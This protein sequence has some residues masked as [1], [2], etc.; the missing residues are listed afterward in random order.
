MRGQY[1]DLSE[2]ELYS[3]ADEYISDLE[4]YRN[5]NEMSNAELIKLARQNPGLI[6]TLQMMK[7]GASWEEAVARNVDLSAIPIEGDPDYEKWAANAKARDEEYGK[8]QEWEQ[9][10][11]ANKEV[12]QQNRKDFAEENVMSMEQAMEFVEK[13]LSP[14]LD[15]LS[16]L[17]FSKNFLKM[18]H[19]AVTK[20]ADVAAAKEEGMLEGKNAKIEET[21]MTPPPAGDGLPKGASAGAVPEMPKA[22]PSYIDSLKRK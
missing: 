22:K 13:H 12:S 6:R 14:I 8:A 10:L 17:N 21:I 1:P 18:I 20:E 16:N 5:R 3:K 4:D 2:D 9:T 11:A 7:E 15:E 19:A